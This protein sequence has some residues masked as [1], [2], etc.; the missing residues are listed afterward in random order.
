M[1]LAAVLPR[2]KW[3]AEVSSVPLRRRYFYS[4]EDAGAKLGMSRTTAYRAM[5]AGAIP[6]ERYGRFLLVRKSVWDAEVRRLKR[7]G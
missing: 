1:R 3:P 2:E 5:N 7:G 4:V 6:T